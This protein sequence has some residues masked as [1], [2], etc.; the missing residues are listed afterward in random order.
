MSSIKCVN[1]P[2]QNMDTEQ[3]SSSWK[4]VIIKF[5]FSHC[6]FHSLLV[7]L[8]DN[9]SEYDQVRLQMGET[10]CFFA[11]L[12]VSNRFNAGS[13]FCLYISS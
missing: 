11:L 1:E 10:Y 12:C 8:D 2:K 7:F 6:T 9:K 4:I 3:E 5:M 13:T